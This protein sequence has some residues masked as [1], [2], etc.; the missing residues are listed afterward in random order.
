MTIK[1]AMVAALALAK[2]RKKHG[3]HIIG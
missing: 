3:I 1:L 2:E